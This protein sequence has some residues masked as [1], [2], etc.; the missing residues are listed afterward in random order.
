MSSG[1]FLP[2]RGVKN[3]IPYDIGSEDVIAS[4]DGPVHVSDARPIARN[5]ASMLCRTHNHIDN[6]RAF[7]SILNS[8]KYA[9][10]NSPTDFHRNLLYIFCLFNAPFFLRGKYFMTSKKPVK[11]LFSIRT[12]KVLCARDFRSL[13]SYFKIL[14]TSLYLTRYAYNRVTTSQFKY[15]QVEKNICITI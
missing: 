5:D 14:I 9:A 11:S 3:F 6:A 13:H 8:K 4:I 2:D 7:W 15:I 12:F 10:A 1:A